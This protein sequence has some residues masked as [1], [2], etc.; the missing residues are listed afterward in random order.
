M[1]PRC[2]FKTFGFPVRYKH[3]AP[4]GIKTGISSHPLYTLRRKTGAV[5]NATYTATIDIPLLWIREQS[6]R[7]ATDRHTAPL[8]R[9]N[10][11]TVSCYCYKH[12]APLG[13]KTGN[14]RPLYIW[15]SI[16]AKDGR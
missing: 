1:S 2:G 7:I 3:V 14:T 10:T 9:F 8:E 4:L 13:I 6:R 5:N 16:G 11:S 15:C 12:V